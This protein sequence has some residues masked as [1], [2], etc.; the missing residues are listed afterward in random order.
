M[1]SADFNGIR[2]VAWTS[3]GVS[4]IDQRKLPHNEEYVVC[5]SY[6][7]VA[8]AI[9][10]MAVRGAPA[11]GVTAA[12]GIALGLAQS[13]ATSPDQLKAELVRICDTLAATRPTAVN[14]FWA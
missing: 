2:T 10:T 11:I 3:E 1:G 4:L 12:L 5:R 9:R 8:D 14:L 7:E 13:S 6:V